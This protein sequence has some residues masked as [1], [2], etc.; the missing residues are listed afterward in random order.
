MNNPESKINQQQFKNL[1]LFTIHFPFTSIVSLLHRLSGI[2]VFLIIPFL[3]WLFDVASGSTEG[4]QK[5]HA[6]LSHSIIK[7]FLWFILLS[8]FYH[9]FA[10]IRHLLMDIG[11]GESLKSAKVSGWIVI[12]LTLVFAILTGIWLW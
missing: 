8:I 7:L 4:F 3:L 12:I 2:F 9:V 5:I 11:L 6:V 10:G 1:N